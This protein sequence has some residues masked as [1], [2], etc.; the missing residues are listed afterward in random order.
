MDIRALAEARKAGV[1]IALSTGR[2]TQACRRIIKQLSLDGFHIF[3][4]GALVSNPETGEEVYACPI[5]RGIVRQIV[6][7][8]HEKK[9]DLDLFSASRYFSERENWATRI[10][11]EFFDLEPTIV[12]FSNIWRNER[13]IKGTIIAASTEEKAK[14]EEF[15]V[16]FKDSLNLSFTK[17]PAYPEV[18]FINVLALGVSKKKALEALTRY[19][20]VSLKE[21]M[22]I[23]DGLNDVPILSAV[24][25]GI[26]MGNAID[27]VRAKAGYVTLDVEHGGVATAI[28]KFLL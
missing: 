9:M 19:I 27:K 2:A 17:T 14:A 3:F 20:G 12:D 7:F 26:A 24:G 5:N 8:A 1:Q 23:G 22:A 6:V 15:H 13:I 25:L 28:R 21:V 10:R 16:H 18:D 11:R 4:D